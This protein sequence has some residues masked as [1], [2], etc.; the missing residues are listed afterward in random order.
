MLPLPHASSRETQTLLMQGRQGG[1]A[2]SA[3][4]LLC[5]AGLSLCPSVLRQGQ[6]LCALGDKAVCACSC[7]KGFCVTAAPAGHLGCPAGSWKVVLFLGQH[8]Y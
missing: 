2:P 4:L 1:Q 3:P 7:P 5:C 6:T 8:R